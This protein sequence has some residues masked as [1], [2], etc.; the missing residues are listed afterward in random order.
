MD[1][2]HFNGSFLGWAH[3]RCKFLRRT[4]QFTPVFAHN[5]QNCD[6]HHVLKSLQD[7]NTRNTFSVIPLNDEKFISLTCGFHIWIRSYTN[8]KGNVRNVY[9]EIRFVDSC[10]FMNISLDELARN[11]PVKKFIYLNNH[12]ASRP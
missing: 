9:E 3:N 4:I 2:N 5:L 6:L 1:Q 12:F 8:E 7:T 11:L 10:K